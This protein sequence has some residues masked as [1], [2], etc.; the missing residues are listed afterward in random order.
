MNK[1]LLSLLAAVFMVLGAF[2][3]ANSAASVHGSGYARIGVPAMPQAVQFFRDV[4]NCEPLAPVAGHASSRAEISDGPQSSRPRTM[5]LLCDADSVVELFENRGMGTLSSPPSQIAEG[6]TAPVQLFSANITHADRWL[7]RAG[8]EVAGAPVTM[9]SGPDAGQT[10][11]NFV[12]PWG[13]RLQLIG[14]SRDDVAIT[15]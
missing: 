12:A 13:L 9:S 8:I 7:R 6:N 2:V 10:V 1:A 15:P 3:P 14:W 11:V 4:L 5:L